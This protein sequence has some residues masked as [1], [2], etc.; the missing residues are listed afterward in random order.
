MTTLPVPV[1]FALPDPAWQPVEPTSLGVTNAAFLALR[2]GLPGDYDPTITISG[3]WRTDGATLEQIADESLV[4]LQ[5]QA[6][7]VELVKRRQVGSERAPAIMQSLGAVA[8]YAGRTFDLRQVQALT[9]IIAVEDPSQR[10]VI[11]YSLTCTYAQL[12]D[13]APEFERFMSSVEVVSG[14]GAAATAGP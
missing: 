1:R 8:T 4:K 13:V 10:A 6:S 12:H 14:D 5:A 7:E 2:G 11:I 9:E 3:D